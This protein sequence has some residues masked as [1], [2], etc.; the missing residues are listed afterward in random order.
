MEQLRRMR[1]MQYAYHKK[2]FHGLYFFLVLVLACL[3]WD[4][5]LS[6]ALV[7][8]LV[9]TAGTLSCFYLHFV[10]FARLHA[11]HLETQLNK[12]LGKGTLVGSEIED[13]YFYPIDAPKIGGFVPFTPLRFFSFFTLHWVLLWVGLAAFALWRLHSVMGPCG[14]EYMAILSLWAIINPGYLAWYFGRAR[15]RNQVSLFLR[16]GS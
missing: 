7:P 15:D 5:P 4:S 1:E 13:L 14:R 6:L 12:A 9:I 2:F 3:F 11:R 8:F 10:D 16:T